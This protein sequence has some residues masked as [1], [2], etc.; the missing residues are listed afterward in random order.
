ML[1]ALVRDP[2][3][4]SGRSVVFAGVTPLLIIM[5]ALW[6]PVPHANAV[7][8]VVWIPD[9]AVIRINSECEISEIH[10]PPSQD[11]RKG[12]PLFTCDD[13]QAMAR[14]HELVA[15][16][17]ELQVR[18][19]GAAA[20]DPLALGTLDAEL[21]AS[22]AALSD[23]KGRIADTTQ[24]AN[25]DGLFDVVGT[26]ALQ[27]RPQKRGDVVGYIIPP[28]ERTVRLAIDELWIT[29]FD[30]ELESVQL[31]LRGADGR[32]RVYDTAVVR[33][34]PKATRMVASA[35]PQHVRWRVAC[36]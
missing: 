19:A 9:K 30:N 11:V 24:T 14:F 23:V 32:Y 20:R 1:S 16:V 17:D 13:P 2:V 22:V 18:R 5:I 26:S 35:A 6:L 34:T 4:R 33:R 10:T 25:L 27:G 36:G 31:R 8:G 15:R 12:D 7:T 29:R 21:A 28:V 3:Y